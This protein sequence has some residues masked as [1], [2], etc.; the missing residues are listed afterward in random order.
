MFFHKKKV[1]RVKFKEEKTFRFISENSV[2]SQNE[3]LKMLRFISIRM[4]IAKLK[5]PL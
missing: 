3:V 1:F 2:K 5:A 4:S